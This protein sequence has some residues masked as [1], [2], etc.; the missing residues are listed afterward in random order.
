MPEIDDKVRERLESVR[1]A[2]RDACVRSGRSVS[3]VTLMAVTKTKPAEV[4]RSLIAL[5]VRDFGENYPDETA[6]KIDAFRASPAD[7]RLCMIGSLQSRK[8]KLV[9]AN[10]DEFHSLD[11]VKREGLPTGVPTTTS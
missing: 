11:S 9:A 8:A 10:F 3:D 1:A 4:I 6:G 5:G 2:I 7:T